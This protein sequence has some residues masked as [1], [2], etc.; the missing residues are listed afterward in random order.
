MTVGAE[1]PEVW[2]LDEQR[3]MPDCQQA[4]QRLS[5]HWVS[6]VAG[7]LVHPHRTLEKYRIFRSPQLVL[8]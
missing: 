4:R 1:V 7:N 8:P 3:Q 5:Q 6:A 2:V